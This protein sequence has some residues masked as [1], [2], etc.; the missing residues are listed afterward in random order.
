MTAVDGIKRACVQGGGHGTLC[1]A[2]S[3][4]PAPPPVAGGPM[5][6]RTSRRPSQRRRPGHW[7]QGWRQTRRRDESDLPTSP[8]DPARP[9]SIYR[10]CGDPG[11]PLRRAV[12]K[13][14]AA[15]TT[16]PAS[17]GPTA[18]AGAD[19]SNNSGLRTR[20][21]TAQTSPASAAGWLLPHVRTATIPTSCE[22]TRLTSCRPRSPEVGL[23][24][25]PG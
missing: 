11:P 10:R 14:I 25:R 3:R 6:E 7:G 20:T 19:T 8:L 21:G 5:L 2:T 15:G 18:I 9:P 4:S 22:A 13:T 16:G 24:P 12:P 1:T 23:A 17:S